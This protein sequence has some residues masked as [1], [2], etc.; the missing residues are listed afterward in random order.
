[1]LKLYRAVRAFLVLSFL[2]EEHCV[3]GIKS[4]IGLT[5]I[6]AKSRQTVLDVH[7]RHSITESQCI[8]FKYMYLGSQKWNTCTYPS[9]HKHR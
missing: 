1:M 8:L 9:F 6:M 3:A 7:I 4:V 2:G 5:S